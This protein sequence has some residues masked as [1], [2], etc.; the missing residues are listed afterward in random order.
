[1]KY[2]VKHL[3]YP[4][5]DSHSFD[6]DSGLSPEERLEQAIACTEKAQRCGD[7]PDEYE[8]AEHLLLDALRLMPEEPAFRN[9]YTGFCTEIAGYSLADGLYDDAIRYFR[10]ALREAPDDPESWLDLGSAYANSNM[11]LEALESWKECLKCIDIAKD[12]AK[13]CTETIAQNI[14]I[15]AKALDM[16]LSVKDEKKA[17]RTVIIKLIAALKVKA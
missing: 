15:V 9:N 7:D 13:E 1:M 10:C 17:L 12:R 2:G 6:D 3:P 14:L 8:V 4:M 5:D 16:K 11:P